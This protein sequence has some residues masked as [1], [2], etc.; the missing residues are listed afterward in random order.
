MSQGLGAQWILGRRGPGNGGSWGNRGSRRDPECMVGL[1]T[2]GPWGGTEDTG[3][4]GDSGDP[5][6]MVGSWGHETSQ[7]WGTLEP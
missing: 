3:V 7:A 4:S 2:W 1:S 5:G 6:D